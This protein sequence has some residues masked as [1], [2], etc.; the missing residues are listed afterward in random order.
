MELKEI[1]KNVP[2]A[3]E[4]KLLRSCCMLWKY[5]YFRRLDEAG[6]GMAGE[7]EVVN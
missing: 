7:T 5:K 6:L 2:E 3:L 1:L 4:L